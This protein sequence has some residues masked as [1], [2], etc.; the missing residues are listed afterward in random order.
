MSETPKQKDPTVSIISISTKPKPKEL[1]VHFSAPNHSTTQRKKRLFKRMNY[2]AFI[3]RERNQ[4]KST[5]AKNPNNRKINLKLFYLKWENIEKGNLI[6]KLSKQ[7]R[8]FNIF[9]DQIFNTNYN[10]LTVLGSLKYSMDKVIQ[11]IAKNLKGDFI[12]RLSP[13]R[14]MELACK[15]RSMERITQNEV[16]I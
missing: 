2:S 15:K 14:Q 8:N 4:I 9:N 7:F 11:L 10:I 6:G 13:M 5:Q 3:T 12:L 16:F 1:K